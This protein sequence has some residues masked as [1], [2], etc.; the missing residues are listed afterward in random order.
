M[1]TTY[2]F[3]I[4]YSFRI[5]EGKE[6]D[7]IM[8]WTEL[9]NLIYEFAGSYGSR[10]HKVADNLFVA[11]AQWPNKETFNNAGKNLP[12]ISSKYRQQMRKCCEEI[13]TDYELNLIVKDLLKSKQH[14][15][16]IESVK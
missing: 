1:N 16:F 7:F 8:C 2:K 6:E 15:N 12:E 11:Y 5:I 4:I 14:S 13:K 3:T 9:T 10:L